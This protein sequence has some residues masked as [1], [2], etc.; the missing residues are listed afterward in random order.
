VKPVDW[1]LSVE[2]LTAPKQ[3]LLV[4]LAWITDEDGVTFKGQETVAARLAHDPRWVREHLRG[5]AEAGLVTR[6]RRHRLNGSRTTDLLVLNMPREQPI[7]LTAYSGIVGEPEPGDREPTGGNPPQGLPAGSRRPT[8]G[9]PPPP[10]TPSENTP[11]REEEQSAQAREPDAFP[12]ELPSELHDA[13]LAAGKILKATALK[14]GQK[15]EVTRAAVGH[16]VLTFPDRDHVK[17]ARE[18]EFWLLHGKGARRSCRDIAARY[19]RFLDTAEPMAGPPLPAGV[20]P[21]RSARERRKAEGNW[22]THR[23]MALANGASEEEARAFAT[24]R[25]GGV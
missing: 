9:N 1:A 24:E 23:Y 6:L 22:S 15:R 18:L 10:R 7:D 2:G 19:R 20:A 14:R 5:L 4:A 17:V 12:D 21:L 13:A 16:A 3:L 25:S 8:G 11:S